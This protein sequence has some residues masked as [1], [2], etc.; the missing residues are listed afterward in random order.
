VGHRREV[1]ELEELPRA[2]H[3]LGV[4]EAVQRADEPEELDRRQL[5][6]DCERL[7]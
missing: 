4:V 1:E 5:L 3:D 7:G 6:V 2:A